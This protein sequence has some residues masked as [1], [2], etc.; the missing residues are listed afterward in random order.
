[1][2]LKMKKANRII[3]LTS[4]ALLAALPGAALAASLLEIYQQAL[5]SDPLIHEAEA[6]RM[7]T[8]EAVPQA[9][10]QL[11]PQINAGGSYTLEGSDG[12]QGFQLPDG[13]VTA[14][15]ARETEDFRWNAELRQTV[16]RWD[17]F[18]GLEQAQKRVAK[19]EV[20]FELAQQDLIVRVVTRY[21]DV[22]A[23]ED[24]LT[25]INADRRAI[26][27]QL[28]QAKQRFEVGL[29]AITDVQESQAA[30]D[31]SIAA[32][33]QAKRELATARE[34]LREI[35]GEYIRELSAP[36][37]EFPLVS[38]NPAAQENWID[39]AM[40]QNLALVSSR[41]DE[42][43]ARDEI[44]FRRTG[45]YPTV[46]LVANYRQS[47]TEISN[48]L[49]NGNPQ[50]DLQ[51]DD[52]TD[53]IGIQFSVPLFAGGRV[54]SRVREA[55][56]L[57]RASREQLQRVTR[58][59]ER[60]TRDAYL[61]VLSEI[62]RVNALAQAV[63]SSRTALEATQ[64]GFDVG[65][66]TIVDV[67]ISQRQLYTAITNYEQARYTYIGNVL[68]LKLAAGTLRIQDLEEIDQHLVARRP[69]E[70]VIAEQDADAA[71]R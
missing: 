33:I 9:R 34:L 16:F 15:T 14:P 36:K 51:I 69:P 57:H 26:A 19:A 11:F 20:D 68:R 59:T 66:R 30:Y 1:M 38:P 25:S 53:S 46:D 21:F 8:L 35:T 50:P 43:I 17:Q 41:F 13:F 55:V 6:R 18:V 32:E 5:Q 52:T 47:D 49:I 60:Q 23:A 58:E 48:I 56:Y 45:H 70:D 40:D 44:S 63:E 3:V 67:L 37:D 62:S 2:E 27:R 24:R 22:L 31:Q 61:G 12:T 42:E 4:T 39:I 64:A 65:T 7:A 54:S 71:T 10:G 29:I 28:E